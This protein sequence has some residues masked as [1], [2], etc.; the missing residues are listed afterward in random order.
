MAPELSGGILGGPCVP[1]L[2]SHFDEI[3]AELYSRYGPSV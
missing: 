3:H 1:S 2:L